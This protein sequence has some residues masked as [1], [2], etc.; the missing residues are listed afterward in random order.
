MVSHARNTLN[1]GVADLIYSVYEMK[2]MPSGGTL[3]TVIGLFEKYSLKQV[4]DSTKPFA[5][6]PV[7]PPPNVDSVP[8]P[9]LMTRILGVRT[10]P[11]LGVLTTSLQGS[12]DA[13]EVYRSWGL[14][15]Q[16]QLYGPKFRFL[17]YATVRNLFTGVLVHLSIAFGFL[18][19]LLPPVR[20]LLKKM[21]FQP[22]EGPAKE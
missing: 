16:G 8:G 2:A 10:V 7:G 21:V 17:P 20:A 4:A 1:T 13:A 12:V 18:T 3:S 14:I 6:S 19:L 9:S 11:D 15:D 5:Q 22:G